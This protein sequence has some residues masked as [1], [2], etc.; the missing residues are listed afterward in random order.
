M[1]MSETV[2]NLFRQ[3]EFYGVVGIFTIALAL[4]LW[5]ITFGLPYEYHPDEPFLVRHALRFGTGDLNPHWFTYPSFFLYLLFFLYGLYFLVGFVLG[6]FH[7]PQ[8]FATLYF[9]D[10]SAFYLIGRGAMAFIGALTVLVLY[11]AGRRL[12]GQRTGLLAA[13]FLTSTFL[14]VQ[15]S[16]YISAV[17]ISMTFFVLV[18]F[19]FLVR[20]WQ[21]KKDSFYV[22]AG[23]FGGLAVANK[24]QAGL[25]VVPLTVAYVLQ[26]RL[27]HPWREVRWMRGLFV[28][29]LALGL[30]F[31]LGCPFAVLDF[32]TF[33]SYILGHYQ[34]SKIGWLG[35]LRHKSG[36]N[37]A[38]RD[39]Q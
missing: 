38:V 15:N 32:P 26:G 8:D 28:G 39:S 36:L 10:P 17:D 30:G 13:F 22:L 21:E 16:H 1:A 19:Y 5:G 34:Q 33:W 11:G 20:F 37:Q 31:L 9:L 12:Y 7:S 23:L 18:S 24:Y 27:R 2:I 35:G 29:I 4:R 6:I 25:I 3:R 14:H